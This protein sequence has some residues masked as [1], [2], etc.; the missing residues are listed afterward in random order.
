MTVRLRVLAGLVPVQLALYL[1]GKLAI[2]A[3]FTVLYVFTAE[4]FPTNARHS[5]IGVC[6]TI[7]RM[8]SALAPQTPLLVSFSFPADGDRLPLLTS[9]P[10]DSSSHLSP[11]SAQEVF[12]CGLPIL[13]FGLMSVGG[14]FIALLLPETLNKALP[15][16]VSQAEAVGRA[17]P[18]GKTAAAARP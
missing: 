12:F 10:R 2:T 14:A 16:N 7:G 17:G 15:D 8:G 11:L 3:S 4:L 13:L 9:L 5:M 18:A 1:V 6:S